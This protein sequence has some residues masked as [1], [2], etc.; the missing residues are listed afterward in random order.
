MKLGRIKR[1]GLDGSEARLVLVQPESS[2]VLDLR[3]GFA[4]LLSAGNA[5]PEAA[6]RLAAAMFTGSMRE[7]I[8]AGAAF[9]DAATDVLAMMPEA[10]ILPIEGLEWLPATDPSV[11]RDGLTF[12]N[13]IKGFHEKMDRPLAPSLLKIPGY[14][15]GTPHTMLGHEED[16]PWPAF[17]NHMDYELELG[18]VVGARGSDLTPDTAKDHLF[19]VTIFNDVSARDRQGDEMGIGMG[20]QKSKDFAYPVGPWITTVD[21]FDDLTT[22]PMEVRVNGEV[23]GKGNSGNTLWSVDELLAYVSLAETIEPG[24]VIGSGT[25][26]GGSALELDRQLSPGDMVEMEVGNIGVLRNRFAAK[27]V[28]GWWPEERKP[29]M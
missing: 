6:R 22:I 5:T 25:M 17:V 27:S 10:A 20:P 12:I 9:L 29:F 13:H 8:S 1:Q 26:G 3:I 24:D 4:E 28:P 7:G 11:I 15:K 23:W 18:W 21:E 2:I 14:F 19:G 16:I